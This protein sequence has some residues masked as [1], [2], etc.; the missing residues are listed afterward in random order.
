MN[1][2][3]RRDFAT[4]G[5]VL[6]GT[7]QTGD[8]LL[9]PLQ[10][11]PKQTKKHRHMGSAEVGRR[12][13]PPFASAASWSLRRRPGRLSRSGVPRSCF[14]FVLLFFWYCLFWGVVL[15]CCFFLL[16]FP[17]GEMREKNGGKK[18]P[19]LVF[20]ASEKEGPRLRVNIWMG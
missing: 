17:R 14:L 2:L 6:T 7:P 11:H 4:M 18:Q 10:N 3:L 5:L 1:F 9:N 19:Q 15:A 20:R 12:T 16:L 13:W 8:V